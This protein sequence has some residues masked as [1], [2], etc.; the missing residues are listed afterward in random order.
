MLFVELFN[1]IL[2]DL[3]SFIFSSSKAVAEES[4]SLCSCFSFFQCLFTAGVLMIE[5]MFQEH[6]TNL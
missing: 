5:R 2:R 6:D 4:C 1:Q 3:M